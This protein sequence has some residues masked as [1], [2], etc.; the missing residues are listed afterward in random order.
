MEES[1]WGRGRDIGGIAYRLGDSGRH[2]TPFYKTESCGELRLEPIPHQS[3][4]DCRGIAVD[5]MES[6]RVIGVISHDRGNNTLSTLLLRLVATRRIAGMQWRCASSQC[7]TI[8]AEG[9]SRATSEQKIRWHSRLATHTHA[10]THTVGIHNRVHSFP[11]GARTTCPNSTTGSAPGREELDV[12]TCTPIFA[13]PC[14]PI[15]TW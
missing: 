11:I 2:T 4:Q 9:T 12:N 7:V 14:T 3:F 15:V 1:Q 8:V 13:V 6:Q 10:R 5:A